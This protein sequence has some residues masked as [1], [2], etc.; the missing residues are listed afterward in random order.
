MIDSLLFVEQVRE[1]MLKKKRGGGKG[2][3]RREG[4][5]IIKEK[6][7]RKKNEINRNYTIKR[8]YL[9]SKECYR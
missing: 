9:Q 5:E 2:G 8:L 4:S 1:R 6:E 3:G 7:E